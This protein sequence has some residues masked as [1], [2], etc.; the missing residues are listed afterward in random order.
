MNNSN[1]SI[2][3]PISDCSYEEFQYALAVG[4]TAP[5]YLTKLFMPHFTEGGAIVNMFV[6]LVRYK[7]K[8]GC[9]DRYY[10]AIKENH[11]DELSQA[12]EGCIRYEYSFSVAEDEL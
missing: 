8:Q 7:C 4:V 2:S 3:F 10:K 11:I 1:G 5:F 6:L 12:E 9:R